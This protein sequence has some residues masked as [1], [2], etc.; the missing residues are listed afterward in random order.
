MSLIV[1]DKNERRLNRFI[2]WLIYI[3]GYAF[4]LILA[5]LIFKKSFQIDSSICGLWYLLASIIV[6]ALNKTIKP[7]IV[8]LTL[9]LTG[10][11]MG[12]FYPFTN[13]IILYITQFLLKDHFVMHGILMAFVIA[14][15]ISI[16]NI[17]MQKV[18]INSI[19]KKGR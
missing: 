4:V 12:L 2:D 5:S 15:F 10:L 18:V 11:T 19:I 16:V 3:I 14:V 1:N 8:W 17:F 13:V 6:Y 9:P 7:L